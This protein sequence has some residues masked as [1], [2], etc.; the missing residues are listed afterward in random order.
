[1]AGHGSKFSR[2]MEA[3]IAALLTQPNVSEAARAVGVS[4]DT[5]M[6]WLKV[7][8]FRDAYR[9]AR[10]GVF[11]QSVSRLQQGTTQA[12]TALLDIVVDSEAPASV[13]VWAAEAILSH[14]AKAIEIEDI[15]ARV[16]A[17]EAAGE[18]QTRK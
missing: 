15:E 7:P 8:A 9:E 13:R 5:L 12:A 1:M 4:P 2:K 3:A 17:L 18:G 6:R 14:S 16:S 10:R 11:Q